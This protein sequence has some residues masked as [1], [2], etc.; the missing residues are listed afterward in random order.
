VA[1]ATACATPVIRRLGGL[2]LRL[3]VVISVVS[4]AVLAASFYALHESTGNALQHRID[5]ELSEQWSEF[6]IAVGP[7]TRTVDK[8]SLERRAR[9]FLV[10]QRYHPR[11]RIF[12]IEVAN[13]PVVTNERGVV[14][15]EEERERQDDGPNEELGESGL[16]D[17]PV[18]LAT[19]AGRETGRL[20]VLTEPIEAGSLRLGTFRVA[21]PLE[22]VDEAQSELSDAFVAV[23]LVAIL[24]SIA[25]GGLAATVVTRPLRRM[26]AVASRVEAGEL[27]RR[28]G[29]GG[30][31]DEV[32]VLAHA[33]DRMLDRLEQSFR[34]QRNFVSD[35][36]HELRTPLTVLRGQLELLEH[37]RD[38]EGRLREIRTALRELDRMNRL[39]DDMLTLAAAEST[40][41]V[42][43]EPIDLPG[44]MQDLQRDLPLLGERDYRVEGPSSGV[45]EADPERLAQVLR[46]L[47]RNSISVTQPGE[48]ITINATPNDGRVEF[49]VA[50]NG[51]GI[52]PAELDRIFD[53]FHRTDT[54]RNRR[55]GGTGLGLAIARALV[56]AHDGRIWAESE[57][58][59]GAT[60]RFELP[61]FR[62]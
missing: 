17:A 60:V 40:D 58:G 28:S 46:N 35:A 52:P 16:L 56:E 24:I 36:S 44:F 39:V 2:R 14:G 27:A 26:A 57:P 7:G 31:R 32:G 55:R 54:G 6:V 50:D 53:R 41:I 34:R 61:R 62:A 23:G 4:V 18:G 25:I 47:A 59:A 30:R 1:P 42:Q 33:F 3:A 19:V 43:L 10:A 22:P 11:S 20:R 51:P 37:D 21:D 38:A 45:L 8:A 48:I 49:T 15:R 5:G 9:R 29:L 12:A 13:G